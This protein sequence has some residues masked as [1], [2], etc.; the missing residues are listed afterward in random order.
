M[1]LN[2]PQHYSSQTFSALKK[3]NTQFILFEVLLR[4]HVSSFINISKYKEI[5]TIC[6][7]YQ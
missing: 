4:V 7:V 6:Q 1:I 3:S 2:A 5:K